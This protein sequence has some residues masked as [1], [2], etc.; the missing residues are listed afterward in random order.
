M[1]EHAETMSEQDQQ[2]RRA[3]VAEHMPRTPFI[4]LL[5]LQVEKFE[6]DDVAM[7]LP[8]REDLTNEG[9]YYHGGAIA[10]ALDTC[11]ALAA[12]SNHDFAKGARAS[13]VGLSIQYLGACKRS[14]LFCR[15]TTTRRGKELI[16]VDIVGEDEAG[17]PVAHAILTYRIVP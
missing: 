12:W 1:S 4:S 3:M 7:R 11:G 2:R 17:N 5:G 8:F 6:P 14:D 10:G 9:V 16:F 15:A 13:T